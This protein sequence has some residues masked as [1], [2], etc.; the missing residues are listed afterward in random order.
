MGHITQ[1]QFIVRAAGMQ[2]LFRE[3]PESTS[4]FIIT[5]RQMKFFQV[6]AVLEMGVPLHFSLIS[7]PGHDGV[8]GQAAAVE[9]GGIIDSQGFQ[10]LIRDDQMGD[11]AGHNHTSQYTFFIEYII[12]CSPCHTKGQDRT[13][14]R[15]K[16]CGTMRKTPWRW[17]SHGAPDIND[18]E[19][20]L[21]GPG[22]SEA[23]YMTAARLTKRICCILPGR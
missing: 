21:C 1:V 6:Y 12:F 4:V 5:I 11:C 19:V 2:I 3:S 14:R 22:D 10:Q 15:L 9:Q 17:K 20:E 8:G 18:G 23:A 16:I 7:L 13:W